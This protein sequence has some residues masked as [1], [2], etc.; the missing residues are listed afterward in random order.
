[1]ILS[2]EEQPFQMYLLRNS[3]IIVATKALVPTSWKI[4]L[5]GLEYRFVCQN[6]IRLS[7]NETNGSKYNDEKYGKTKNLFNLVL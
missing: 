4:H 1:M 3:K 5:A 2:T 7:A 6:H